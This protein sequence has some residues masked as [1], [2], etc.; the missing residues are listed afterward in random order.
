[1]LCSLA[2]VIVCLGQR[3]LGNGTLPLSLQQ[4]VHVALHLHHSL[5]VPVLFTGGVTY[6]ALPSE[7]VAMY[8]HALKLRNISDFHLEEFAT[9]TLENALNSLDIVRRLG[10]RRVHL[11]TNEFHAPR[12]SRIFQHVMRM[13]DIE[14]AVY[15]AESRLPLLPLTQLLDSEIRSI[16]GLNRYFERYGLPPMSN[17]TVTE[18][19]EEVE[20]LRTTLSEKCRPSD[21]PESYTP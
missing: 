16:L 20:A 14:V 21:R 5:Q 7:A 12:A 19:L 6:P 1:M 4:R 8:E 10:M 9:N 11:V 2:T 17:E 3:L 18:I 13:D 15:T